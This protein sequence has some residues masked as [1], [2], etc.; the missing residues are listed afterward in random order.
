[1]KT[2][3]ER[4]AV[5]VARA[6]KMKENHEKIMAKAK[7]RGEKRKTAKPREIKPRTPNPSIVV[8][9]G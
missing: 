3:E 4:Q 8:I 6:N 5:R 1:M 2:D 9:Q 7:A